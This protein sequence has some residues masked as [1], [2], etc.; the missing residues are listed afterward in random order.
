MANL[1][2]QD[3]FKPG[4][5]IQASYHFNKDDPSIDYN[6]DNFLVRPAPVGAVFSQGQIQ[7]NAIRAHYIG[8][9]GDG[10]IGRLNIN[11]A[12][13]QVLGRDKFNTDRPGGY[14]DEPLA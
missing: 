13:Y 1:Y 11:H 8:L 5:T 2:K 3:F 9:T 6:T 7:T 10:H 12:F 4:Y 14:P